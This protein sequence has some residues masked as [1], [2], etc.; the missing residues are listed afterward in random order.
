MLAHTTTKATKERLQAHPC[1]LTSV[2]ISI[3]FE[4]GAVCNVRSLG[5][6]FVDKDYTDAGYNCMSALPAQVKTH[7]MMH[8]NR[9][10]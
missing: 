5:N 3:G 10:L 9:R 4:P 7:K 6:A 8:L 2:N 1:S